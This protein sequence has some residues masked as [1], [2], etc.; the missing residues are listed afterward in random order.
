MLK[1][2]CT[3]HRLAL[4]AAW[5]A[6]ASS[7]WAADAPLR[8]KFKAGEQLDYV[9]QRDVEGKMNLMGADIAFKMGMTFD[10]AWKVQSVAADGTGQ[11]D[12]IVDRVQINM[13]SPLGGDLVFDS[14]AEGKLTGPAAAMMGPVL[15]GMLGQ[16]IKAKISS[17]GEVSDI[18]LPEKLEEVFKKQQLSPNRQQGFGAGGSGFS[19]RGIKELITKS[20]LPLPAENGKDVSWKQH[21]EN[22]IMRAGTQMTDITYSLAGPATEEGKPVTKIAAETE[23]TFEPSENPMADVEI[24]SQE[25]KSTFYF[26]AAAGRMLKAEGVQNFIMEISGQRE[27]TQDMKETMKMYLGKSPEPKPA[28]KKEAEKK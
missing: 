28:E 23:L 14:K 16:P 22:P 9:M 13:A 8:W 18:Q 6:A 21:F 17:L 11:V 5:V 27:M 2:T 26:D 1:R 3:I 7:A 15:D 25:G 24:T 4:L 19:E 20:V 12:L 10:I